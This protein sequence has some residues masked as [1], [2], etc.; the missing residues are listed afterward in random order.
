[1][2]KNPFLTY[3][4]KLFTL[5]IIDCMIS[6]EISVLPI[7]VQCLSVCTC[8]LLNHNSKEANQLFIDLANR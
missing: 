3:T 7:N 4:K 2:S 8:I 1:M 5:W 6:I